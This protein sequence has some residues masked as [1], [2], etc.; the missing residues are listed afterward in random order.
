MF[1]GFLVGLGVAVAGFIALI[2]FLLVLPAISTDESGAGLFLAWTS[3]A[4]TLAIQ[5]SFVAGNCWLA[6][7][8][9][10][11]SWDVFR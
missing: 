4:V 9:R 10:S 11:G 3:L 6:N 1:Y 8:H 2:V 7:R 5:L